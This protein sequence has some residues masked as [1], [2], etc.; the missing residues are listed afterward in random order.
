MQESGSPSHP[1]HFKPGNNYIRG[2][3]DA[4]VEADVLEKKEKKKTTRRKSDRDSFG[5]I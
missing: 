1:G 4:A 5:V 2:S 3:V